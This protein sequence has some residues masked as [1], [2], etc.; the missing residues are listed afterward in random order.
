MFR[1]IGDYMVARMHEFPAS[2][3]LASMSDEVAVPGTSVESRAV[4]R[5]WRISWRRHFFSWFAIACA[6]V[7]FA[8]FAPTYFLR[9]ASD[10]PPLSA[11][12]HLHG[13]LNT[14]WILLLI[15]Q[16]RLVAARRIAMHRALGVGGA[17]LAGSMLIVGYQVAID[18]G[19]RTAD[20]PIAK[21]LIIPMGGLLVFAVLVGAGLLLRRRAESHKRLMA[22]ATIELLN[23]AV[24]RLP[25]VM[26]AGLAP[27]YYGTDLLLLALVAHDVI[28]LR[29]IHPATVWGG[30]FLVL[31]Q[32]LRV[33]LL[34]SPQGLAIAQWLT[35]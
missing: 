11:P 35:R 9:A 26:A 8:G 32:V 3:T 12:V 16:T 15:V 33:Q 19:R 23:A 30:G 22:L 2:R 28:T 7:V 20:T 34:D 24:D 1:L 6:I 4:H 21:F 29:R 31:S 10:Q 14:A 13:A 25:G 5:S 27:F 18:F 17:V